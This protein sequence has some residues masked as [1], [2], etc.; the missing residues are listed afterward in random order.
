MA[1]QLKHSTGSYRLLHFQP[2]PE[3]GERVCVGILLS[4]PG[5]ISVLYDHKFTKA[6]CVAPLL[7]SEVLKFYLDELEAKLRKSDATELSPMLLRLSPQLAASAPRQLVSPVTENLKIRLLQRF[8]LSVSTPTALREKS[9]AAEKASDEA[10]RAYV[11]KVAGPISGEVLFSAS[12]R[13][14]VGHKLPNTL[15]IAV[16]LK[17]PDSLVLIDGVDLNVLRP[18]SAVA[19]VNQVAH[20]FWQYGR[21]RESELWPIKRVG[22]VLNGTSPRTE[23]YEDAH[24]YALH[25][26]ERDADVTVDTTSGL[27]VDAFRAIVQ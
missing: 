16:A 13:Q 6:R 20:T 1:I 27:G 21:V 24:D 23:S 19:K 8:V 5:R 12:A 22:L 25:Q 18:G 14:I 17:R 11:K 3:D 9:A 26:F 15:R 4:E 7:Q 2:E 10:L